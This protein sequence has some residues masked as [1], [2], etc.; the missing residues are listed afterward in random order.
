[1]KNMIVALSCVGFVTVAC[2]KK[3]DS[4]PSGPNAVQADLG[5]V[6]ASDFKNTAKNGEEV[7]AKLKQAG[8]DTAKVTFAKTPRSNPPASESVSILSSASV[9]AFLSDR[10]NPFPDSTPRSNGSSQGKP[11]NL[12]PKT[13]SNCGDELNLLNSTYTNTAQTLRKAAEMLAELDS[14]ELGDGITRLPANDK[15]AVSY[16]IDLSKLKLE[17]T[18][19]TGRSQPLDVT[20]GGLALIGAGA[21]STAAVL[22]TGVDASFADKNSTQTIKG[23]LVLSA[24][25]TQ[26]LLKFGA[27]ADVSDTSKDGNA[28]GS[29]DAKMNLLAG[30]SPSISFELSGKSNLLPAT[31]GSSKVTLDEKDHTFAAKYS[32]ERLANNDVAVTYTLSL[33]GKNQDGKATL[34]SDAQ[35]M[36]IVKQ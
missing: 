4:H 30:N 22:S 3:D 13:G 1:M 12:A 2:G 24:E 27:N 5:L 11:L 32:I 34:T 8:D 18:D 36:C 21:N 19:S 31:D 33:D 6:G 16:S 28:H 10:R 20:V 29:F 14:Q 35:G 7:S 9:Q 15:F 25:T 26:K 23:G 17:S